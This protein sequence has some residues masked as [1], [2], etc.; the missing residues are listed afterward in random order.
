MTESLLNNERCFLA[1]PSWHSVFNS[2]ILTSPDTAPLSDRSPTVISL[3]IL[4]SRVSA[5]FADITSAIC[6]PSPSDSP[7]QFGEPSQLSNFE[8]NQLEDLKSQARQLRDD[9]QNWRQTYDTFLANFPLVPENSIHFNKSAEITSTYL[10]CRMIT[11]RLLS[12]VSLS[13]ST[14]LE[15][16]TQ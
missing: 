8:A 16:E 6:N 14:E 15:V 12:S 1:H 13:E 3:L 7:F 2:L 5:L 4:K 10:S 9:L 11:N